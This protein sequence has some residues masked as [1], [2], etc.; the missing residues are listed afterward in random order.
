MLQKMQKKIMR[1]PCTQA[2]LKKK[3]LS[4]KV[5]L[6]IDSKECL[7]W[8]KV[9]SWEV[10]YISLRLVETAQGLWK[11]DRYENSSLWR[12]KRRCQREE[13]ERMV[14]RKEEVDIKRRGGS[15]EKKREEKGKREEQKIK[16]TT[17]KRGNDEKIRKEETPIGNK[18]KER[19]GSKEKIR[20]DERRKKRRGKLPKIRERQ[21]SIN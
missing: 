20:K 4:W 6:D 12:W 8:I 16:E 9:L 11:R 1:M 21:K 10:V 5:A 13:R 2:K 7:V 19:K 14:E 17:E 15:R 18:R 3:Y